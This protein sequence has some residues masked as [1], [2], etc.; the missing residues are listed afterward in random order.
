MGRAIYYRLRRRRSPLLRFWKIR[1]GEVLAGLPHEALERLEGRIRPEDDVRA[2]LRLLLEDPS[3]P[4]TPAPGPEA[5]ETDEL[6]GLLW[7]ARALRATCGY[8]PTP[9]LSVA[10]AVGR[11]AAQALAILR[12]ALEVVRDPEIRSALAMA[13]EEAV[14]SLREGRPIPEDP[15]PDRETARRLLSQV[16][17]LQEESR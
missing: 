1:L 13:L 14:A 10:A 9:A 8:R 17:L 12:A 5:P 16:S 7:L 4:P 2:L 11:P 3:P 6:P 15:E